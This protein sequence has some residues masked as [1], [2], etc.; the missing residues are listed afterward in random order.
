MHGQ[1]LFRLF[2][3]CAK[4]ET[5]LSRNRFNLISETLWG[6]I[7]KNILNTRGQKRKHTQKNKINPLKRPYFDKYG[8]VFFNNKKQ[9]K[10]HT[11]NTHKTTQDTQYTN[12]SLLRRFCLFFMRILQ[13]AFSNTPKKKSRKENKILRHY[14]TQLRSGWFCQ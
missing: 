4:S 3:T 11:K 7:F 10:K 9:N 14:I 13:K 2:C 1:R 12:V 5:W 8:N 6:P